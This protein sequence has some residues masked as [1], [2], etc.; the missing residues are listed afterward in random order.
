MGGSVFREAG[1]SSRQMGPARAAFPPP[2]RPSQ[3]LPPVA[4]ARASLPE[5]K[6]GERVDK[7]GAPLAEAEKP[8]G[9]SRGRKSIVGELAAMNKEYEALN[10]RWTTLKAA[11]S[12]LKQVMEIVQQV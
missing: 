8:D 11:P 6:P 3:K 4:P 5:G 12:P 1:K 7:V 10:L 2:A 9:R